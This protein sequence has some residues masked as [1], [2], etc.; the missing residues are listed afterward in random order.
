MGSFYFEV[1]SDI[2]RSTKAILSN[3]GPAATA[4]LGVGVVCYILRRRIR[5]STHLRGPRNSNLFF[6]VVLQLMKTPDFGDI[7]EEWSSQYGSVFPIPGVL[8]RRRIILT[9]PKS[10]AHFAARETY[11]Y[12]VAPQAKHI[13]E[14]LIGRG[15]F[16][17]EGDSHKSV[18]L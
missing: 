5:P 8:G 4:L 1:V 11:G 12:V 2:V 3:V 18:G 10:L 16:W 7:Y 13:Q 9:D 6:G 14:K 17:A 15:L